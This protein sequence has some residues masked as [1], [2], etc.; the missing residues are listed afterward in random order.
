MISVRQLEFIVD[1]DKWK[2]TD[3][4]KCQICIT[5]WWTILNSSIHGD[6]VSMDKSLDWLVW[7]MTIAI[8][9]IRL[10]ARRV[11]VNCDSRDIT[12][13]SPLASLQ[14]H[15]ITDQ[16]TEWTVTAKISL[17]YQSPS[18][19]LFALRPV[20]SSYIICDSNVIQNNT[21]WQSFF[22]SWTV[23]SE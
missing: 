1:N 17:H 23:I 16:S 15:N 3:L 20:T 22:S 19:H 21:N 14:L 8:I 12:A 4:M 5:Y 2:A 10:W 18:T 13:L 9:S 7:S 6:D 11:L